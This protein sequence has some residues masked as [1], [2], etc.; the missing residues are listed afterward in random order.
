MIQ[1]NFAQAL[2]ARQAEKS[3]QVEAEFRKLVI[4]LSESKKVPDADS[5]Q[6]KLDRLGKTADEL[7]SA[8]NRLRERRRL[9][10]LIAEA[11]GH[12]EDYQRH[13]AALTEE[14]ERFRPLRESHEIRVRELRLLAGGARE[15]E[16]AGGTAQQ[17]LRNS[18]DPNLKSRIQAASDRLAD[19][20]GRIERSGWTVDECQAAISEKSTYKPGPDWERESR[21]EEA[22]RLTE[23]LPKLREVV[24]T[25]ATQ[26]PG[27][28]DELDRLKAEAMLVES[29]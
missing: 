10:A 17:E 4:D 20:N 23:Q 27:L 29:F 26:R 18:C 8:L 22:D 24:D 2:A 9:V 13:Q 14:V 12:R 5:L 25:L 16:R 7:D 6:S 28:V 19:L 15:G 21:L 3:E 1:M 11:P